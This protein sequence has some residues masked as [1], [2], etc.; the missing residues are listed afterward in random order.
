MTPNEPKQPK[1]KE[2]P[3]GTICSI[4]FAIAGFIGYEVFGPPAVEAPASG[5][6]DFGRANH[7]GMIGAIIGAVSAALGYGVGKLI[8]TW[9]R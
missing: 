8:E 9:R 5:G 3:V 2:S 7:A 4:V 1:P 6:I